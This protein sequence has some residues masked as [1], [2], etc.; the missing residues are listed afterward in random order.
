LKQSLEL[1][2]QHADELRQKKES[3]EA[4]LLENGVR[5]PQD[6]AA[7]IKKRRE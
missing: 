7:Q 6:E 3:L 2:R 5:N 4:R 1:Q